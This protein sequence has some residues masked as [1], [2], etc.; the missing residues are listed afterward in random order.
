LFYQ[1][2]KTGCSD[3]GVYNGM[4][5]KAGF[6]G[7]GLPYGKDDYLAKDWEIYLAGTE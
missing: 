6:A 3:G 5:L 7:E 1:T 4:P 2:G